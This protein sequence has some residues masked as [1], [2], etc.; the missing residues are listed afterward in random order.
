LVNLLANAAE[1]SPAGRVIGL[2]AVQDETGV[3]VRVEDEGPGLSEDLLSGLRAPYA[4]GSGRVEAGRGLALSI[5]WGIVQEHGGW[6]TAENRS[7]RGTAVTF[8]IPGPGSC[9][10]GGSSAESPAHGRTILVVDDDRVMCETIA[11]MLTSEGHRIVSV[12]S[13]EEAL[14]QIESEF[15]DVVITDQRLPGMNGEALIAE[16]SKR[17]PRLA[18][19]TVLT[20]GLLFRPTQTR[21]YLQK[22]FSKVRLLR[23]LG[24]LDD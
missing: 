18:Q 10:E 4:S 14:T 9:A 5:S 23:L 22:P 24:E 7:P 1:S 3:E 2:T 15:F 20:S 13:A 12:H 17:W 11:W 8:W 19:R 21:R 6:L 16:I